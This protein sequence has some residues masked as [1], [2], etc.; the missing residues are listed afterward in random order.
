LSLTD[1]LSSSEEQPHLLQLQPDN[2]VDDYYDRINANSKN[3]TGSPLLYQPWYQQV[4]Q[5]SRAQWTAWNGPC[6]VWLTISIE[7]S[8][9][10]SNKQRDNRSCN[11]QSSA[12]SSTKPSNSTI[13]SQWQPKMVNKHADTIR[14]HKTTVSYITTVY[15]AHFLKPI[16]CQSFENVDVLGLL[17]CNNDNIRLSC[18]ADGNYIE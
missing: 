14:E 1:S 4:Q 5:R 3:R 18:V 15:A 13:E 7:V 6:P 9:S 16:T 2:K 10:I 12:G 11:N 8:S 17:L